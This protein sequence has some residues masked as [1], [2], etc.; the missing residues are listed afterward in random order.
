MTRRCREGNAMQPTNEQG[1]DVGIV[2]SAIQRDEHNRQ[3]WMHDRR[4]LV[5]A[6]SQL[7]CS[8][9]GSIAQS[10]VNGF[11]VA[12]TRILSGV[13]ICVNGVPPEPIGWR[14]VG[15]GASQGSYIARNVADEC[16]DPAV[17]IDEKRLLEPDALHL[18]FSLTSGVERALDI[19]LRIALHL[20]FSDM[21]AI[22]GGSVDGGHAQRHELTVLAEKDGLRIGAGSTTVRV[23]CGEA[24]SAAIGNGVCECAWKVHVPV[25]GE[26]SLS[27]DIDVD[28]P[29][30]VVVGVRGKAPW[31]DFHAPDSHDDLSHWV[32]QSLQDLAGLRMS[33]PQLPEEEF[34]AAG[35]P[36]F[37]TL[38]GRDS[39]WAARFML[40]VSP[41]TAVGTLRILAHFQANE[42]D[43]RTAADPGK[44]PHELRAERVR[45]SGAFAGSGM[46][47]PPLYYGTVDA[48]ALW[49]ILFAQVH[50]SS[51]RPEAL[52][53]LVPHLERAL[54]W[55]VDWGDCDGDGFV[56]YRD[57]FGHGLSNQGWK[58]SG[59]SIRWND[60]HI[61][62]GPIALCEVQGYAYQAAREGARLLDL[63][64]RP[65][66][67]RLRGWAERLKTRFNERFWVHDGSGR[68]PAIALDGRKNP[69]DCLT[70]NI[71]H[72]LGTGILDGSGVHDVVL[73]LMS[74]ELNSGYG[75]RTMSCRASGY[76]PLSY[77]C[78]SVWAHDSAIIMDGLY[79]EGYCDQ[80]QE[81]AG[82]L[83]RAAR[84]FDYQMPELYSGDS[85]PQRPVPYPAACHPQA[86]SAAAAIAVWRVMTSGSSRRS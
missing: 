71:G 53:D 35:A 74:P 45:S 58:D 19:D 10:G 24:G 59:D 67:Q 52:A 51:E 61:A 57:A 72:L 65:G 37:F 31:S 18:G 39:L 20:D 56:E 60:G 79:K 23:R 73:R 85:F 69:V 16:V 11:Y 33:I 32:A 40:P 34:L 50:D 47:L 17:R 6:P 86:W 5:A 27:V 12:D 25:R 68:Y 7:W 81:I 66:S 76:W 62:E 46:D 8:H 36:W 55:L 70:S 48:T 1:M 75:I 64:G 49:I 4:V 82:G 83:I 3:P 38:F 77:H 21:Q 9:D 41:Q 44:M 13:G 14:E 54:A 63:Y 42:S 80:A 2:M 30:N 26:C 43:A 29:D 28:A 78:G 22:K 15:S 84:L